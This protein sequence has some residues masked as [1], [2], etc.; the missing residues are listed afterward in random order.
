MS[1]FKKEVKK[2]I[3]NILKVM[4]YNQLIDNT[5]ILIDFQQLQW[6]AYLFLSLLFSLKSIKYG[7][8]AAENL[9]GYI[10]SKKR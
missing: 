10:V 9:T 1:K 4:G 7:S 2:A 6:T 5:V 8:K 3:C